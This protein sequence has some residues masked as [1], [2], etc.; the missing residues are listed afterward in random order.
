MFIKIIFTYIFSSL[1]FSL[2]PSPLLHSMDSKRVE[3]GSTSP[4]K[5]RSAGRVEARKTYE[6]MDWMPSR[7]HKGHRRYSLCL[8]SRTPIL[9]LLMRAKDEP[10]TLLRGP[11]TP[12]RKLKVRDRPSILNE[13]EQKRRYEVAEFTLYDCH[14]VLT[15]STHFLPHFLPL[16][17]PFPHPHPQLTV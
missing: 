12:I 3:V 7:K 10:P 9:R 16:P 1:L 2:L 17:P 6:N 8:V 4:M 15:K 5:T 14:Q 11:A 13:S